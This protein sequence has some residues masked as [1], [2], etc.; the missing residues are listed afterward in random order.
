LDFTTDVRE[1]HSGSRTSTA[2]LGPFDPERELPKV[3]RVARA[4]L[5]ADI[6]QLGV[7][8]ALLVAVAAG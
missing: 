6:G 8:S 4:F 2:N 5:P 3:G 1:V 7:E